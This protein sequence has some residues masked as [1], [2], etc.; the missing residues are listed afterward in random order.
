MAASALAIAAAITPLAVGATEA[1]IKSTLLAQQVKS[2]N[3]LNKSQWIAIW[4]MADTQF[5]TGYND[6]MNS[7]AP[8]TQTSTAPTNV[9]DVTATTNV[10]G[11]S[12]P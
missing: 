12:A 10:A 4:D 1:I 11:A 5:M 8:T 2:A 3:L 9:V 7:V 6:V